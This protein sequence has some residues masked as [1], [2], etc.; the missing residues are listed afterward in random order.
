MLGD[1]LAEASDCIPVKEKGLSDLDYF[2]VRDQELEEAAAETWIERKFLERFVGSGR[3][4]ACDFVNLFDFF[5]GAGFIG[6]GGDFV[7]CVVDQIARN[8]HRADFNELVERSG[9]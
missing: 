7:A 9:E 1:E 2:A 6:S 5:E 8:G 4:E 3:G